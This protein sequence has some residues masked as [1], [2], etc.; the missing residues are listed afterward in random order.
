MR[1]RSTLIALS[2]LFLPIA[3]S[4][5]LT[6]A[7]ALIQLGTLL[8]ST[9]AHLFWRAPSDVI[10]IFHRG[11]FS[12]SARPTCRPP[13]SLPLSRTAFLRLSS[14]GPERCVR[15]DGDL[16]EAWVS[17]RHAPQHFLNFLPLPQG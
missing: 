15:R 8:R 13:R 7:F 2:V 9:N 16:C 5:K 17:G 3:K 12:R 4:S 1:R 11:S 6:R 14:P 10:W